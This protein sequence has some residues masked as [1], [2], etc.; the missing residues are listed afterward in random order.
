[1]RACEHESMRARR[2]LGFELLFRGRVAVG[3]LVRLG[4]LQLDLEAWDR[5]ADV[6]ARCVSQRHRR[7]HA[8]AHTQ[9]LALQTL[10]LTGGARGWSERMYGSEA[11]GVDRSGARGIDKRHEGGR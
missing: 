7:G 6:S 1:M 3:A 2:D 8:S 11:K 5:S 9:V 10:C 4:V